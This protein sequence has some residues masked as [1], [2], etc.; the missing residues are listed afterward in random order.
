MYSIGYI[1]KN[2][3]IYISKVNKYINY[4]KE[5]YKQ[6]CSLCFELWIEGGCDS[7]EELKNFMMFS[8]SLVTLW[9]YSWLNGSSSK[10]PPLKREVISLMPKT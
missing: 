6:T 7:V 8:S 3:I 4:R 5:F 10:V 9:R 1:I 2:V